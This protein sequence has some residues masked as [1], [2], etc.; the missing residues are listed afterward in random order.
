M[1]IRMV[2]LPLDFSA[3]TERAVVPAGAVAACLGA[4]V[5]PVSSRFGWGD[6]DPAIELAT[7]TEAIRA[8]TDPP[9]VYDRFASNAIGEIT[10]ATPDSLVCMATR[11]RERLARLTGS[12]AEEVLRQVDA[13]VLLVGPASVADPT[14]ETDPVLICVDGS[15]VSDVIVPVAIEWLRATGQAAQFVRVVR[16]DEDVEAVGRLLADLVGELHADL[17]DRVSWT[18]LQHEK[19]APAIVDLAGREHVPLIAMAT[20]GRTGLS[21]ATVGNVTNSVVHDAPCP[22]LTVRPHDLVH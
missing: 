20:H 13:P 22:V 18:V 4:R 7:L 16:H 1:A 3:G 12:V 9:R 2:I 8:V 11:G 6:K 10:R 5:L 14:A 21:R 19:A 17:T 15:R